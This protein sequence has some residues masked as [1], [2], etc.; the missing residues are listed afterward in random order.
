M[1]DGAALV[2][3]AVEGVQAQTRVLMRTLQ[4]LRIPTLI[5][6]NKIDRRGAQHE[7]T[8]RAIAE[9]LTPSILPMGSTRD[10]G[11]RD[12]QFTRYGA[13]DG[14]FSELLAERLTDHDEALLAT[15]WEGKTRSTRHS[16]SCGAPCALW[17]RLVTP[18]RWSI[19]PPHVRGGAG[20]ARVRIRSGAVPGALPEAS[21]RYV[22]RRPA[23][24][25]RG[26]RL[27]PPAHR[28]PAIRV[29]SR[30]LPQASASPA[31][32][33]LSCA[34]TRQRGRRRAS[35]APGGPSR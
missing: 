22:E 3:S 16:R 34:P 23:R 15:L 11:T 25:G 9:K 5:F 29:E 1:L 24:R 18:G 13:G 4:R 21:A 33:S 17:T 30:A 6:V 31:L 8:L 12:A 7:R 2:V 14:E 19:G 35:A 26:A 28:A 10:L 32:P 27:A 20:S